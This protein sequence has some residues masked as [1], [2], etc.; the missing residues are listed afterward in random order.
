MSKKDHLANFSQ[1]ARGVKAKSF[2]R[3]LTESDKQQT[4]LEVRHQQQ[5]DSVFLFVL[6]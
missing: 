2:I 1:E 5:P 6:K 4:T 3:T